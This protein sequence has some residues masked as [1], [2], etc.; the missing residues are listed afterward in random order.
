[1]PVKILNIAA[2]L[3]LV[4][5][6]PALAITSTYEGGSS[7]GTGNCI[8]FGCPDS[9]DPNMGFIYKN[10]AAFTLNPGDI[11][12]FDMAIVNDFELS[13]NLSLG[14]TTVNGGTT[15]NGAGFTSVAT[16]GAGQ[17]G[18]T[19]IGNYDLAFLVNTAFSFAGGGLIVDFANTNGSV[20]D[21]TH[22]GGGL[23]ASNANPYVVAR[24]YN[25]SFVGDMSV[26]SGGPVGNMRIISSEASIPLPASLPLMLAALGGLGMLSWR[27]KVA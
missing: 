14:A 26:L 20:V 8:P 23:V 27:R 2:A 21:D 5:T 9:Y 24:Y 12:A 25:G 4:S 11:I 16:L 17:Y 6:I 1:M 10:I 22:S 7:N 18:D 15:V 19:I 13:M 3:F